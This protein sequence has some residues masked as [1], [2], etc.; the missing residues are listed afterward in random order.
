MDKNNQILCM[1]VLIS[2]LFG[3]QMRCGF[4]KK[5]H[6]ILVSFQSADFWSFD[7][8]ILDKSN[9]KASKEAVS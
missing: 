6:Q 5:L 9:I 3:P 4:L 7:E 2:W 8:N 1:P